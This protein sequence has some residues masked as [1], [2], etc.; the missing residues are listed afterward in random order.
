MKLIVFLAVLG[1]L[2]VLPS[3]GL[4]A[5]IYWTSRFDQS[6]KVSD[7]STLNTSTILADPLLDPWGIAVDQSSNR[8]YF[9][10]G[11]D[12]GDSNS[13]VKTIGTNGTGLSSLTTSNSAV[14]QIE[15]DLAGGKM[16][17]AAEGGFNGSDG[18]TIY[19]ASLDGSNKE[20]LVTGLWNPRGMTI[21]VAAG[22][23]YFDTFVAA[24]STR[25]IMSSNL[26][27]SNQLAVL[28]GQSSAIWGMDLDL[29][30]HKLY[31]GTSDTRVVSRA[32]LDGTGLET[33]LSGLNFDVLDVK[34]DPLAGYLYAAGDSFAGVPGGAIVRANLDGSNQTTLFSGVNATNIFIADSAAAVPEPSSLLLAG[35]G[36][37]LMFARR[38]HLIKCADV[39]SPVGQAAPDSCESALTRSTESGT[40]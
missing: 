35:L 4:A 29:V 19:R 12:A 7:T 26:D 11:K 40:A 25:T 23:I 5:L 34:I 27:G 24:T 36:G 16:Y 21:D 30:N 39:A 8:I 32:N 6:I 38:R 14:R 18:D 28:T 2:F 17:W 20:S 15:L 3:T 1:F 37:F 33:V 13:S 22:K 10:D 9:T 31:W